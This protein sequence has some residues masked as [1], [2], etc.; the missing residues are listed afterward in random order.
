M[1]ASNAEG[2]IYN[3]WLLSMITGASFNL[4]TIPKEIKYGQSLSDVNSAETKKLFEAGLARGRSGKP[5]H[6]MNPPSDRNQLQYL[7]GGEPLGEAF[8][9]NYFQQTLSQE[10]TA[11]SDYIDKP[12][13][14][15]GT[16]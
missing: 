15:C 7:V 5:W 8:E 11:G 16:P 2:G 10:N 4:V 9:R 1:S 6:R 12:A 3:L 14:H 13:S